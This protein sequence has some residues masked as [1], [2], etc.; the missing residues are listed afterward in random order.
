MLVTTAMN[1]RQLQERSVAFV[2][3]P[4]PGNRSCRAARSLRP[5][6]PT[7]PPT[8]T[9]GSRPAWLSTAAT[10]DVVVVLPWLP[11][12][13]DA[14]LLAHQLGQQLAARDHRNRQ[15]PRFDH[16]RIV[17]AHRGAD[18]H[19]FRAGDIFRRVPFENRRPRAPSD[20]P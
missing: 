6:V 4:P 5:C 17:G 18:H 9:V 2:R 14:V 1:R 20:A 10:I 7:R 19:R 11:A 8:T 15:P 13:R 12:D 3:S 16:F